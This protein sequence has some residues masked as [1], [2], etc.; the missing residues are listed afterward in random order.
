MVVR[1][2]EVFKSWRPHRFERVKHASRPDV[3]PTLGLI[4][5]VPRATV[6][7]PDRVPGV[8]IVP[9]RQL[10]HLECL[11]A[12]VLNLLAALEGVL[13]LDSML[14]LI[15]ASSIF[16]IDLPKEGHIPDPNSLLAR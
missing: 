5:F 13:N 12:F 8:P 4:C 10:F 1:D 7:S 6:L 9:R 3:Y 14:T 11:D 15:R 2:I 16:G